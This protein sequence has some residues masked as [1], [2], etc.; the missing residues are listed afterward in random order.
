MT[1]IGKCVW[2][3]Y[4]SNVKQYLQRCTRD[5]QGTQNCS[6]CRSTTGW[7][8]GRWSQCNARARQGGSSPTET[9]GRGGAKMTVSQ[10]KRKQRGL[11]DRWTHQ[12]NS[13][14]RS[15]NSDS[16][17]QSHL[18]VSVWYCKYIVRFSSVKRVPHVAC[19]A[20][21]FCTWFNMMKEDFIKHVKLRAAPM[22]AGNILIR[23][24]L[25]Y[26]LAALNSV[27]CTGCWR[28]T[29]LYLTLL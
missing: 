16:I 25:A 19:T 7:R 5:F 23:R 27:Y 15:S 13:S 12:T 17:A 8:R 9:W 14:I 18:K 2:R 20:T 21:P 11:N 1:Y 22:A 29:V 24:Y 3:W 10:V 26:F 4:P 6:G 28:V